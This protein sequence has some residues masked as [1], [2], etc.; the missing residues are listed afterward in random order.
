M[1]DVKAGVLR[2]DGDGDGPGGWRPVEPPPAPQEC[3]VAIVI[4]GMSQAVLMATPH[5]LRD[6]AL[7]FALTEGLIAAPED[8]E[9]FEEAEVSAGGFPAREARLWLRP[10]LAARLAE[11]RRSMIGPVGC[12]LC[13]VDS[14]E[15]ALPRIVPVASDWA[16]AP[17]DVARAM[18]ALTQGQVLR[19]RTPAIHGAAFWDG[20]RA[21]T[22]EDVGRHNALDKLAGALAQAGR[23]AGQGAVVMSS[24]L[25]VDL[26]Q[27]AARIGAPIL[28][29]ASAPTALALAWAER[30][31]ITLIARAR[32]ASFD[33][34]THPRRIAG[35]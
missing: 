3:P 11:R 9:G 8:V 18:A 4:D 14:I 29:G 10:G 30:A 12:G 6:F 1:R 7:G 19:H 17:E 35:S 22:R 5:D 25:S 23:S 28:I 13:G 15:A 24:R 31:G 32:H 20:A 2:W 21:V 34:Y 26:V 33:L 16:M 27:K